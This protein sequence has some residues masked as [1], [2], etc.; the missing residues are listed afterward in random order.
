MRVRARGDEPPQA[1]PPR[2]GRARLNGRRMQHHI[3]GLFSSETRATCIQA[4]MSDV[5]L[6]GKVALV[7]GSS[8][9]IGAGIAVRFAKEGAD[10]VINYI[11]HIEGAQDTQAQITALGRKSIIVKA[12]VSSVADVQSMVNAGWD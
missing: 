11:G 12:D 8:S 6:A 5:R 1:E 3:A 7:T 4:C 9:G 2:A 10:V